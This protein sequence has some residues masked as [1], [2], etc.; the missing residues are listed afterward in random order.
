[1]SDVAVGQNQIVAIA[2]LYNLKLGETNE[3]SWTMSL[4]KYNH[5]VLVS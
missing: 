5:R 4:Q 3:L 1:M 2:M